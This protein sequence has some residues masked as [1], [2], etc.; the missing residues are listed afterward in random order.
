MSEYLTTESE[1]SELSEVG[2]EIHDLLIRNNNL[3]AELEIRNKE[4]K[5]K[6]FDMSNTITTITYENERLKQTI[7]SYDELLEF[8]K[9]NK[10]S[11]DTSNS[12]NSSYSTKNNFKRSTSSEMIKSNLDFIQKIGDLETKNFNLEQNEHNLKREIFTLN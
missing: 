12:S 5:D 9:N 1:V 10:E 8:Y 11:E 6:E 4:Y 3:V 2:D 7:K